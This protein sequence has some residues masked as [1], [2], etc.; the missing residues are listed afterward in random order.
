MGVHDNDIHEINKNN[1]P[2]KDEEKLTFKKNKIAYIKQGIRKFLKIIWNP[3][4]KQLLGNDGEDWAKTGA[5][6]TIFYALLG[7]FT[8]AMIAIFMAITNARENPL[9]PVYVGY[10]SVLS[11]T[12]V[13]PGM[14][15]RPHVGTE[16]PSIIFSKTSYDIYKENLDLFLKRKFHSKL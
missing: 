15:V 14:G 8:W 3:K 12:V 6:Y 4:K 11:S 7:G 13:S 16:K 9:F 2:D 5:F 10:E 1:I